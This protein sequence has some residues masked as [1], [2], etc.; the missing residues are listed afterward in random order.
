MNTDPITLTREH[1]E[2]LRT[3]RG[4]FTN[5]TMK[6][7][8]LDVSKLKGGWPK[9][10]EGTKISVEAYEAAK[11]G[12]T[13]FVRWNGR[14]MHPSLL[15]GA[16]HFEMLVSGYREAFKASDWSNAYMRLREIQCAASASAN[17]A[18]SL[19]SLTTN[20]NQQ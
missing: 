18:A 1:I 3:D 6:A 10:M 14:V 12:C 4:G 13:V 7:L 5:A 17:I 15:T 9:A 8:G 19:A 20:Q 11:A 16:E 2:A